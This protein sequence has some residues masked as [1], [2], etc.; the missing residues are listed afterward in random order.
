LIRTVFVTKT[1]LLIGTPS[2]CRCVASF[3][4]K[5]SWQAQP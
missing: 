3:D 5:E 4:G 1:D 2:G